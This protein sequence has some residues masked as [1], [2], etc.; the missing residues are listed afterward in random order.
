MPAP[1]TDILRRTVF[2]TNLARTL[3]LFGLIWFVQLVHYPLFLRIAPQDFAAWEAEH[4]NRTGWVA[5]PLMVAELLTALLLL[6]ASLRPPQIHT[7]EA[8]LGA[9]LTIVLWLSTF[10]VQVPLHNR[11][12]RGSNP[13]LIRRLIHTNWVRT[14]TWT[15]RA[16]LVLCWLLRSAAV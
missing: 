8:A 4:A 15:A 10:F 16:A 12:H 2:A 13:A 9:A 11:L 5:A 7:Y 14:I 6:R 3:A 1:V